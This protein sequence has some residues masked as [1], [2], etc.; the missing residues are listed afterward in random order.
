M[1]ATSV[2]STNRNQ[3]HDYI[4][5][6]LLFLLCYITRVS[7]LA[8]MGLFYLWSVTSTSF[9]FSSSYIYLSSMGAFVLVVVFAAAL[10]KLS[11]QFKFSFLC[12]ALNSYKPN[13]RHVHLETT[14]W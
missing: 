1:T 10:S 13:I 11:N 12:I 5:C 14:W 6:C 2:A 4:D 8:L 7:S 9:S 3:K